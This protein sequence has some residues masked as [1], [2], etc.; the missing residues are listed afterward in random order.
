L[1]N[2]EDKELE[3]IRR[4]KL[5]EMMKKSKTWEKEET[6]LNKPIEVTDATFEETVQNH[7]L[8]IV[9]CWATWCG[10]CHMVVPIIEELARDYAGKVV[11][12]KLDVD[13]NPAIVMQYQIM[14]VPTLLVFNHG[15][16]VD[17]II[18][19]SPRHILEAQITRH[20]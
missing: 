13:K 18:G 9:D 2:E 5:Q 17:K 7:S 3:R 4:A 20:L 16:L 19:A 6:V 12:G 15:K 10:P 11:F 1:E 8:V 14:S